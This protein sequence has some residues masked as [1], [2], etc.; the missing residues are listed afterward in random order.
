MSLVC[1]IFNYENINASHECGG[2]DNEGTV[3]FLKIVLKW[4]NIVNV[5]Y[6]NK[7]VSYK[8]YD[9]KAIRSS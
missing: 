7:D 8:N 3:Q 5:K 9:Y 6:L 1:K 4:W 2:D